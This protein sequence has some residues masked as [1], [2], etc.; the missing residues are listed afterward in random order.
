MNAVR[1]LVVAQSGGPTP[2]INSSL[3][4]IIEAAADLDG[5]APPD[6]KAGLS[7]HQGVI[8]HVGGKIQV[9]GVPH[10][11]G[12]DPQVNWPMPAA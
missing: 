6:V 9:L 1:N 2:V 11:P 12:L 3:Q 5:I 7:R 8:G 10:E 4:G